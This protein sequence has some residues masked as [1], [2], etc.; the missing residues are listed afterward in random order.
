[1]PI[2]AQSTEGPLM[3]LGELVNLRA[4]ERDDAPIV[5][6]W[7]NDPAVMRGWGWSAP[8]ASIHA[9]TNTIE[10][11]LVQEPVLGHPTALIAESLAGAPVGL[12]VLVSERPETHAVELSM[13]VGDPDSWGQGFG[14]DILHAMLDA[15]F[16]GWGIHRVGVQ[17]ED[18]N[19]RALQLY[20]RFGFQ[21]EGML[22]EGAFRDG[23]YRDI[24]LLSLLSA[25]WASRSDDESGNQPAH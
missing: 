9:V 6:R 20:Q 12:A 18:D 11:W 1:M 19:T 10:S 4:I 25:E 3:I 15:C 16:G 8:A 2:P 17:V 13:L 5:Y 14:S 7:L 23:R 21:P 24:L 22:R